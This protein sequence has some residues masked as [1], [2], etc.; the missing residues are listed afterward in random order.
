MFDTDVR[1][2]LL[3]CGVHTLQKEYANLEGCT[4]DK[5]HD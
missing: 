2:K 5:Q 1:S 3:I 4:S